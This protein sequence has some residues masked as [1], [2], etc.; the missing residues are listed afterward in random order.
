MDIDEVMFVDPE[1]FD[2]TPAEGSPLIDVGTDISK[3]NMTKDYFNKS[4]VKNKKTDIGAIESEFKGMNHKS[5]D[6]ENN[7]VVYPNPSI[8]NKITLTFKEE[9]HIEV[10]LLNFEGEIIH[11]ENLDNTMGNQEIV[12]DTSDL[13]TGYYYIHYYYQ[14]VTNRKPIFVN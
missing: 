1:L 14:G 9:E 5:L 10:Y 11:Q 3:Y 8:D 6:E 13:N 4:R 7:L 12:F 2:F